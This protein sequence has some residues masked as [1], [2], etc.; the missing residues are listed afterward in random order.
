MFNSP[1]LLDF[2]SSSGASGASSSAQKRS[3]ITKACDNCRRRRVKCDGVPEGCG[4]CKAAKTQCVYTTSNTKRGPPKGYVEVIEDRLG[5]IENMLAGI[6]KKKK[7][8]PSSSSASATVK[9]ESS[10]SAPAQSSKT[11]HSINSFHDPGSDFDDG[12]DEDDLD[13]LDD[14]ASVHSSLV[15]V[16]QQPPGTPALRPAARSSTPSSN[17]R[18]MRAGSVAMSPMRPLV[19]RNRSLTSLFPFSHDNLPPH[20][21]AQQDQSGSA[22][23]AALTM[24]FDKLGSTS[25]RTTV[26]FPWLTPEQSRQYGRNHLQ[27][28]AQSLEPPLPALARSFPLAISAEQTLHLLDAYFEESNTFLPIV[29]KATFMKQWQQ[30]I[31]PLC[32][33][34][35]ASVPAKNRPIQPQDTEAH[36]EHPQDP[37]SPLSP[38]LLNALLAIA[39]KIPAMSKTTPEMR[40]RASA[41]SQG[42][43]DAARLLMDDFLDVPRVSTV[44]ALCL[45][46]QFHHQGQWKATRSSGYLSLAIRMAHELGLHRDPESIA[47]VA[48]DGLRCL[49]WS[50]FILDHQFSAWLG[51]GLLMHSKETDVELPEDQTSADQDLRGFVSMVRLVKILGS[52]LQHSYSTQSLPPQFG[53]HDSMVSYIEGS[54]TSWLS[55]LTPEMRW[56]NPNGGRRGSPASPRRSPLGAMPNDMVQAAMMVKEAG[57][58]YPAYLYIVYNTTLILLHRPYIVGAAGSPAAAQSNTICTGSGRAITDIAQGMDMEHCSYVV[59]RFTL[60]ALLQAGVIHAM[61]AVYDKRGSQ[62]AMDYYRRTVRVL[63]TFL[64]LSSYSGGVAE[65]I[66]ILEQFLATTIKAAAEEEAGREPSEA[67]DQFLQQE[68]VDGQPTRKKRQLET[69][70]SQTDMSIMVTAAAA[71]T[72]VSGAAFQS[73]MVMPPTAI[74]PTTMSMMPTTTNPQAHYG[75]APQAT[76]QQQIV[77]DL[78]EQQKQQQLKIQQQHRLYQQMQAFGPSVLNKVPEVAKG[79]TLL[80]QQQQQQQ[81]LLRQQLQRQQQRQQLEMEMKDQDANISLLQQQQSAMNMTAA[82]VIPSHRYAMQMLQ[83]QQQQQTQQQPQHMHTNMPMTMTSM[84]MEAQHKMMAQEALNHGNGMT[85]AATVTATTEGFEYDP[86]RFWV[87]FGGEGAVHN[88]T[89]NPAQMQHPAQEG[90]VVSEGQFSGSLWM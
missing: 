54:L 50:M 59:N 83:Q 53:G 58:M 24:M 82:P 52:V 21:A 65:G 8:V 81:A 4:G 48:V 87:D 75:F 22:D 70:V 73:A 57:D 61:N 10:S 47:G 29:H 26:P 32:P 19:S 14:G 56:H 64:D 6:V 88:G 3:K 60:Y 69:F 17:P 63:E 85:P 13:D 23:M 51:L 76:Q 18:N 5:K 55:N 67:Q 7:A 11:A 16:K 79:D 46:S 86:T 78:K 33:S 90:T 39:A 89:M 43:F 77:I 20:L 27:F 38:F 31:C 44:Q 25:V 84:S 72:V 12:R 15:E 36:K 45:M 62:V 80:E 37:V 71:Q 35:A 68:L 34:S 30:E 9:T 42:F 2:N 1:M 49:W 40:Q 41:L 74:T 28:S 66:K